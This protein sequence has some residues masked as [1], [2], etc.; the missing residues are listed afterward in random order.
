MKRQL[1]SKYGFLI[2]VGMILL[3]FAYTTTWAKNDDKDIK[4]KEDITNEVTR[5]ISSEAVLVGD[6]V[7]VE[8]RLSLNNIIDFADG[9]SINSYKIVQWSL[10]VDEKIP[11]GLNVESI[12]INKDSTVSHTLK[13][14]S[15]SRTLAGKVNVT[16]GKS[17][18]GLP[19]CSKH[20]DSETFYETVTIKLKADKPGTYKFNSGAINYSLTADHSGNGH[21]SVK[22]NRAINL[23]S[24]Q[25]GD[26]LLL[27]E[28]LNIQL[29]SELELYLND[30]GNLNAELSTAKATIPPNIELDWEIVN[31]DI[32]KKTSAANQSLS[33][34]ALE[35]GTTTIQAVYV[36][37]NNYESKSQPMTVKVKLPNLA[38]DSTDK[39]LWVYQDKSGSLVKQQAVLNLTQLV[40]D[41]KVVNNPF[42]ATWEVKSTALSLVSSQNSSA[43]VQA[44]HG[45]TGNVSVIASLVKYPGQTNTSLIEVKEYPQRVATPNV[46]LYMSNSPY[47][48]P[49]KF[50]PE[51]SN[52][53]EYELT[54]LEGTD[55]LKVKDGV[56]T[57]LKPGIAKIGL[58]TENVDR[59][60]PKGD[61]P[62][63]IS[64]T[65]YVRVK[66]GI[67]PNP[68]TAEPA[69]DFY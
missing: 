11:D 16:C 59:F 6:T 63:V 14:D 39:V 50:W 2:V 27:V 8:Y 69:I 15:S 23:T 38:I 64:Q 1:R 51:T 31:T 35:V 41:D 13:F 67:D 26:S 18:L 60:F 61:G 62:E 9:P 25:I 47:E 24:D 45:S 66:E 53:T 21:G 52:V 5:E 42:D 7:T 10:N 56:L 37:N 22:H 19:S 54:V 12:S 30:T 34:E 17:N 57:L 65:F 32:V 58:V 43:T 28:E 33:V 36:H 40:E 46:V 68:G 49:V 3:L 55:V 29:P 4:K 44:E 20:Y 48:Y